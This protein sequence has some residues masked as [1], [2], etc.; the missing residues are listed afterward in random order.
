MQMKLCKYTEMII[1]K[2]AF[3]FGYTK[4]GF[5]FAYLLSGSSFIILSMYQLVSY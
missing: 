1:Y 3:Q 5:Y 2:K 4:Y